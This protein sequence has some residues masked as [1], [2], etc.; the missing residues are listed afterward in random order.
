MP[1]QQPA[2]VPGAWPALPPI[3]S[4]PEYGTPAYY[5]ADPF[6]REKRFSVFVAAEQWRLQGQA[7]EELDDVEWY[8]H[9]FGDAR[10]LASQIIAATN[11]IRGFQEIREARQ[12]RHAP[13]VLQA[14][15]GWPPIAIPG[16]P[17]RWLTYEQRQEA[18]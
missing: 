18:A 12:V 3:T 16:Q 17:G 11:R 13:H 9:T 7:L 4:W 8:V 10:R 6:S 15:P 14:S 1:Q 5:N 2:R